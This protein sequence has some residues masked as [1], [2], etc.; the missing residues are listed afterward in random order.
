MFDPVR[1][2]QLLGLMS[3]PADGEALNA[4]RAA[5]RLMQKAG[6]SWSD[7]IIA[8]PGM[9]LGPVQAIRAR[10]GAIYLP[11]VGRTW[12]ETLNFLCARRAGRSAAEHRML[13]RLAADAARKPG[14]IVVSPR[15]AAIIQAIYDSLQ[16]GV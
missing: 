8:P 14:V 16:Q 3:S 2:R 7:V 15:Q 10:G 5:V 11:P 4:A 13:D 6:L 12:V 9:E 1:L